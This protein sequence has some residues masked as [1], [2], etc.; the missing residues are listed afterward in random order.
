MYNIA[1]HT[2]FTETLNQSVSI[3]LHV[4]IAQSKYLKW[5]K[6][7]LKTPSNSRKPTMFFTR[8]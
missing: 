7:G 5:G 8:E 2:T 1:L 6:K 3:S 4:V